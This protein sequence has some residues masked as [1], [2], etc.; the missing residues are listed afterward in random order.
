[1]PK[2]LIA[3]TENMVKAGLKVLEGAV[4]NTPED[5]EECAS[6]GA[7][8]MTDVQV[9]IQIFTAMWQCK[10]AEE[11]AIRCGKRPPIIKPKL[12]LVMPTKQ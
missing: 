4:E 8:A 5:G 3:I 6:D 12:G 9:V 11:E 7:E 2:V 10:L 1:M